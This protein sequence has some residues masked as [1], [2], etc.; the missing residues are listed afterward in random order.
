MS[1]LHQLVSTQ[2]FVFLLRIIAAVIAGSVIGLERYRNGHPAGMRTFA[3]I[4]LTSTFLTTSLTQ[5]MYGQLMG[6]G[7]MGASRVIQGILQG[8]GFIGAGVI[9][10]EGFSI[11][12]LTSAASIWAVAGIGI[13]IGTG[14][15]YLAG[16]GTLFTF[17]ILVAFKEIKI[18]GRRSFAVIEAKYAKG[19]V[20]EEEDIYKRL[21]SYGFH[22]SSIAFKGAK[23]GAMQI[24]VHVWASENA[25]K[26]RSRLAM[27]FLNDANIADFSVEPVSE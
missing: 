8:I 21:T 12:G 5:G 20:P 3:I 25:A 7:D 27:E 10:R 13:L 22:V 23:S 18:T 11:K 26:A 9:V 4:T 6:Q 1:Y 24:K 19:S 16:L 15:Y 2:E 14:E 17:L